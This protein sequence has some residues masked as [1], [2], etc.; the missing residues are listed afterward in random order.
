MYSFETANFGMD[1]EAIHYLRNRFNYKSI[2]FKDI[3]SFTI[4]KGPDINNW[5]LA[6]ILGL[7]FIA[8]ALYEIVT[9]IGMFYSND[10]HVIYIQR[11]ILPLLPA[12]VGTYLIVLSLRKTITLTII[13]GVKKDQFSLREVIKKGNFENFINHLKQ[14]N[15]DGKLH[16]DI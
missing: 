4:R 13:Y 11:I 1:S 12:L 15:P 8:F 5:W 7:C 16:V 10:V 6:F 9:L 2:P 14:F 3:E